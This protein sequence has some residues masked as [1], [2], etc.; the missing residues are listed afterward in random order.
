MKK[1][2]GVLLI[3]LV[4][5]A[6]VCM[7]L[8]EISARN[9]IVKKIDDFY[10]NDIEIVSVKYNFKLSAHGHTHYDV[11][12]KIRNSDIH[13]SINPDTMLND[14]TNVYW[15][16]WMQKQATLLIQNNLSEN[17]YCSKIILLGES[18]LSNPKQKIMDYDE[19]MINHVDFDTKIIYK[20]QGNFS[21]VENNIDEFLAVLVNSDLIFDIVILDF[22]DGEE[23]RYSYED[24]TS[25]TK[26]QWDY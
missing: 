5:I 12:A 3:V 7:L 24:I 14:Y 25:K 23:L 4:M 1:R 22:D 17:A 20:I 6:I 8:N 10:G 11:L 9:K 19:Y 26:T 18:L 13:F 2:I 15:N 21:N 16:S